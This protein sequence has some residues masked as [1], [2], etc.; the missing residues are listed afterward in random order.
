MNYKLTLEK[1]EEGKLFPLTPGRLKLYNPQGQLLGAVSKL[2]MHMEEFKVS[3]LSVNFVHV[4]SRN[5]NAAIDMYIPGAALDVD[6]QDKTVSFTVKDGEIT[7][8]ESDIQHFA[9]VILSV[10]ASKEDG[11]VQ[12]SYLTSYL[13]NAL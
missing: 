2:N 9:G 6:Y 5:E 13:T 10:D 11:S 1:S 3:G 8:A 4:N 12:V 7:S